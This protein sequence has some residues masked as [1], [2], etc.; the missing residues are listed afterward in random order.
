MVGAQAAYAAYAECLALL[1]A[2][3]TR[4]PTGGACVRA[5]VRVC[6]C[7]CVCV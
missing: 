3:L 7:V 4:V 2:E 1:A 6:V 5:C